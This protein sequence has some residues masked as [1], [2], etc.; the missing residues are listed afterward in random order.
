MKIK[1]VSVLDHG[2]QIE[3]ELDYPE[4]FHTLETADL[5]KIYE[6]IF[7]LTDPK[8]KSSF[9]QFL[10]NNKSLLTIPPE[11]KDEF[12]KN[13]IRWDYT[14]AFPV[15]LGE[16]NYNYRNSTEIESTFE[17]AFHEVLITLL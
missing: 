14:K 2:E 9:V 3:F 15:T 13:V 12:N 16:I 5:Q 6:H 10:K 11:S 17:F 1:H 8:W 4:I 7:K